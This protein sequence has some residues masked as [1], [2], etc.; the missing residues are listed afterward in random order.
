[1]TKNINLILTALFFVISAELFTAQ[2]S[3]SKYEIKKFVNNGQK[4]KAENALKILL[5]QKPTRKNYIFAGKIYVQLGKSNEAKKFWYKGVKNIRYEYAVLENIFYKYSLYEELEE[6]YKKVLDKN[7]ANIYLG[8]KLLRVYLSLNKVHNFFSLLEKMIKV[9]KSFNYVF[10]FDTVKMAKEH[11]EKSAGYIKRITNKY[12]LGSY[13]TALYKVLGEIYFNLKQYEKYLSLSLDLIQKNIY[14][15]RQA[16]KIFRKIFYL[17]D[18]VEI[19]NFAEKV[20][21]KFNYN[22]DIKIRLAEYLFKQRKYKKSVILLKKA[23]KLLKPY[24]REKVYLLLT[25]I[26]I[27]TGNSSKAYEYAKL[28]PDNDM[29]YFL[30]GIINLAKSDFKNA[31]KNFDGTELKRKNYYLA[32]IYFFN[33]KIEKGL[34][35]LNEWISYSFHSYNVLPGFKAIAAINISG[36]NPDVKKLYISFMKHYLTNNENELYNNI[37]KYSSAGELYPFLLVKLAYKFLHGNAYEKCLHLLGKAHKYNNFYGEKARFLTGKIL[38]KTGNKER[39]NK[40]LYK[41]ISD[42]PDTVF[43]DEITKLLVNKK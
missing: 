16:I 30:L 33:N 35:L 5:K 19:I 22:A 13:K 41:L 32:H 25:H 10:L 31:R 43:K 14:G 4:K 34:K 40:V 38:I 11:P 24:H 15:N 17:P 3:Y 42:F 28:L 12:E 8:R 9:N 39:G 7:P 6:L 26:F 21:S 20:I 27:K 23:K 37:D 1:M 2:F 36:Q 18:S 29:K